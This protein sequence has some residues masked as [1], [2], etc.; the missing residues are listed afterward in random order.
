MGNQ[1]V[2]AVKPIIGLFG[3]IGN[4]T[5]DAAD[6]IVGMAK[7]VAGP[8]GNLRD[9]LEDILKNLGLIGGNTRI[10]HRGAPAPNRS[11]S[12]TDRDINSSVNRERERNGLGK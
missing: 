3:D 8:L 2:D 4:A 9:L 11:G 5:N 12:P 7:T 1:V 10:G 6:A